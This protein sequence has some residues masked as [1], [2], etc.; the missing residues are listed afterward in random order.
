MVENFA[1]SSRFF[2]NFFSFK[3]LV[4]ATLCCVVAVSLLILVIK[5]FSEYFLGFRFGFLWARIVQNFWKLTF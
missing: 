2:Q 1:D 5:N 4:A 3:G